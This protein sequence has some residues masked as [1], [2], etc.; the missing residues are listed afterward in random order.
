MSIVT[1]RSM[2]AAAKRVQRAETILYR[3]SE[4][5]GEAM[6]QLSVVGTGLNQQWGKI[7]DLQTDLKSVMYSLRRCRESGLCNLDET[8]S[9][10]L[11][12]KA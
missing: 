4:K 10:M 11:E 9:R 2:K 1:T 8:T 12:K 7:A 3:V 6:V 5:L